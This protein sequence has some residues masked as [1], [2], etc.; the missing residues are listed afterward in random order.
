MTPAST[1]AVPAGRGASEGIV[2]FE[3]C[4]EHKGCTRDCRVRDL[5]ALFCWQ[6]ARADG[7]RNPEECE[8]CSYRRRWARGEIT[9]E[10]FTARGER[11]AA[12]RRER[13][14]LVVDDEPNILYALQE[15][16][17]AKG[18]ECIAAIDGEEGLIL[19]RGVRPDLVITDVIMP[20]LN[21]FELCER[22]KSEEGTRH[23]PVVMV[24]VKAGLGDRLHGDRSGADA[25]LVK[26]FQMHELEETLERLLPRDD[27]G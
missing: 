4:W 10:M 3:F 1:A 24:T 12:P 13:K 19:T 11:R 23:I 17:R 2:A 25:Y 9:V 16:A 20:R 7:F 5:Q 18:F 6:V 14:I 27:A 22:I 8:E 15:V 26:P 21:G